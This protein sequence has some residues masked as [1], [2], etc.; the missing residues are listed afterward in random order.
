MR[1][2]TCGAQVPSP[3]L[4]LSRVRSGTMDDNIPWYNLET[5][6]MMGIVSLYDK[7]VH[8]H[9]RI[10]PCRIRRETGSRERA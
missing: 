8:A 6:G 2:R 10:E 5:H 7:E 4:T 9:G 1:L 3:A